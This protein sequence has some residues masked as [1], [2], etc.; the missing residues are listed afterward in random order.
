MYRRPGARGRTGFMLV[1]ARA[2]GWTLGIV[3]IVRRIGA[4]EQF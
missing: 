2:S 3:E 4:E 1:P